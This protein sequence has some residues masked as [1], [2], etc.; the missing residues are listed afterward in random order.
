MKKINLYLI[1]S[2][3]G[4]FFASLLIVLFILLMQFLWKYI[5]DLIGKGLTLFQVSELMM[6]SIARFVPLAL[7][8][9]VLISSV[10]VI[11]KLGENYEIAAL[12]SSGISLKKILQPLF[13]FIII[14]SS[15]S[16]LFSNYVMPIANYKGGSLL[17]DIKKKKPSVNIKEGIFYNDIDGFSIKIGTKNSN[18]G[19][20][21]DILI[22]DHTDN[23]GNKKV[24]SAQSGKMEISDNEKYMELTLYNGNSY[25]ELKDNKKK[26]NHRKISFSENLIRF[27]LSNFGLKNSE[28]LYKGHYAMLN[29]K[30]LQYSIDSLNKK[31][32]EKKILVYNRISEKYNYNANNKLDST[33]NSNKIS[34]KKI[35]ETAINKLRI[36]KSISNSNSDDINYKKSIIAKHKIEW[37]RKI[38]LSFACVIMFLIGA[39]IG[40]IVRKGGFSIPLL[41]SIILFVTYYVISITGEKTAKDLSASPLEG[42]WIA[43]FIFIP[44]SI[45]LIF[46][47]SNNIKFP[48]ISDYIKLNT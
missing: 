47:A 33:L 22:Y 27:D 43:N 3:L 12:Q 21:Y 16:Y 35:S 46:M 17:Y 8:I 6:Y 19:L 2:F 1:R 23:N 41:I 15:F 42:M 4:P 9:A 32:E 36:L 34:S 40:S 25:I 13:L 29:N 39:P 44:I 10:M 37:H 24:I 28:M 11:G 48:K 5:D 7:P 30:Q 45:I 31:L 14:I 26:S 18:N 20:L 38:S